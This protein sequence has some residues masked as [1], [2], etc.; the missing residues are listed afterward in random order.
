MI[1]PGTIPMPFLRGS[2]GGPKGA[3]VIMDFLSYLTIFN[4][5]VYLRSI[6]NRVRLLLN[7]RSALISL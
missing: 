4:S 2:R 1:A 3:T 6:L 7:S 5:C